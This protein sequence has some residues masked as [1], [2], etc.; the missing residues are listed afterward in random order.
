MNSRH[1]NMHRIIGCLGG[2]R[3]FLNQLL[4]Q[5]ERLRRRLKNRHRLQDREP[6][7]SSVRV[8]SG[9]FIQNQLRNAELVI[10]SPSVPLFPGHLLMARNH[11][12]TIRPGRQVAHE[13]RLDIDRLSHSRRPPIYRAPSYLRCFVLDVIQVR[14]L[15]CRLR[16]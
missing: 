16:Q 8:T 6:V 12:I 9:R 13:R 10:R 3:S 2:Q 1:R 5:I 15:A 14:R 11:D 4:G 7:L